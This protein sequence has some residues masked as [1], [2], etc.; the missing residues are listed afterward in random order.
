[1]S[2]TYVVLRDL[3]LDH[4]SHSAGPGFRSG[5]PIGP[6]MRSI[7]GPPTPHVEVLALDDGDRAELEAAPGVA[8]VFRPM[9]LALIRPVASGPADTTARGTSWGVQAV[10][11]ARSSYDGTG[12]RV[13]VLDTGIDRDHP[14]FRGVRVDEHDFTGTGDGDGN[15]HGTHCAGTVLGREV[16]G[17]RIGVACGVDELLVGKALADDGSGS[18]EALFDA[19]AWALTSGAQVISMS[20]GFDFPGLVAARVADGWPADLAT[21]DALD[22]YRANLRMFDVLAG[23]AQAREPFDG[24]AV[25]IAAAGNESHRELDPPRVIGAAVPAAADGV[26]SVGAV[27]GPADALVVARFSND[28]P[29]LVAPGV[30]IVSARAGGGLIS[31]DGTSMAAPH[32]AGIAALWWEAITRRGLPPTASTV[33]AQLRA[34]AQL[35]ALAPG[36]S[37]SSRGNGLVNAP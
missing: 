10:G 24:G 16:D 12:A 34:H 2:E 23:M 30:D 1:M 4:L 13:A 35:T 8:G 28:H 7:I 21:S 25:V 29:D 36:A 32:V 6:H 26:V 37:A 18:S 27:G 11:A 31:L 33:A 22:A 17:T 5:V 14:A 3:S 15:G 9:P 19:F 20:V